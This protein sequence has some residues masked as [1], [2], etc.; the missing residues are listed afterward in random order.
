VFF[1]VL[2]SVYSANIGG[3]IPEAEATP[4]RIVLNFSQTILTEGSSWTVPA[5]WTSGNNTIE[6]IGGGGMGRSDTATSN[7]AGGGGGGA[8]AKSVNVSLTPGST[9]T[10]QIGQGGN[11]SSIDGGDTFFNRTSG[12]AGTC[13]DTTSV[14][15]KGGKGATSATGGTGGDTG[16]SFA[17]GTGNAKFAGGTGGT[18]HTNAD[19]GGG[20]GGAAGPNGAGGAG[21]AGS[22]SATNLSQSGGGGGGNG[23]GGAGLA[24]GASGGN[25]GNGNGGT[26]SGAGADAADGSNGTAGTGAGGGGGGETTSTG[27][28]GGNGATGSEWTTAGTGGGGGG[29]ADFSAASLGGDGGLYG[30]GG[31]G[32]KYGG[33]GAP[34]LI[35]ITYNGNTPTNTT[36]KVPADWNNSNNTIEVIGAGAS[37]YS[38]S[39]S[40]G[41]TGGGGG[42]YSKATNVSLTAGTSV[43]YSIGKG[44]RKTAVGLNSTGMAGGASYFCNSTS[45][46]ST[47]SD[48]AVVAGGA[49]GTAGTNGTTGVGTGGAVTVGTGLSGGNGGRG[50][51]TGDSSGGGGG[52]GQAAKAG[53]TGGNGGTTNTWGGGGGGGGGDDSGTQ[54][55]AGSNATSTTGGAGGNGRAGTGDAAGTG[56]GGDGGGT[57]A[58]GTDGWTGNEWTNA[59]AGGGGGGAGDNTSAFIRGGD[60]GFAGGGGGGGIWGG[61]GGNGIIVITY[62]PIPIY[63]VTVSGTIYNNDRTTPYDCSANNL[64]VR[65]KVNGAGDYTGTCTANTGAYSISNVSTASGDIVTTYLDG[66]TPDAVDVTRADGDNLTM[67]LYQDNVILNSDDGSALTNANIGLWDGDNDADIPFTSNSNTLSFTG[68]GDVYIPTTGNYAPGGSMDIWG[69]Y[70]AG[71]TV[72][73]GS[74]GWS[75]SSLEVAG[76]SF[77]NG[78]GGFANLGSIKQTGGTVNLGSGN[79]SSNTFELT[80]GTFTSTSATL[81]ISG[82]WTHTAGGT[83]NH[84]N[85]TVVVAPGDGGSA[86]WDVA[87]S[88]TLYNL[89]FSPGGNTSSMTISS[90]DTLV[91]T[92]NFTHTTG[93]LN[94]GTVEVQGSMTVGSAG[95]T[96]STVLSFLVSGSQ[97][98][99]TSGGMTGELN[100]AKASGTLSVSGTNLGVAGFT[101]SSGTFTA[102]TGTLTIGS[103]SPGGSGNFTH[104]A[105]GTFSHN[106][107]TVLFAYCDGC[108]PTV[109]VSTSET[110]NNLSFAAGGGTGGLTI[111]SGD[112]LIALGTFTQGASTH[113]GTGT[114][115]ARGNVV[116]NSGASGG[117]AALTL[118]GSN[119]QTVTS[120][121]TL[122]SGGFTINKTNN[123]DTV[124]LASN[125]TFSGDLTITKGVFSQGASYNMTVGAVS[126]GANGTWSNLGTGDVTLGGD[127]SNAGVIILKSNNAGCGG[128]DDIVLTSTNTTKRTWSGGGTFNL[129]N[130]SVSYM[131]G[132]MTTY[133][134]TNGGNNTSWTFA[135]CGINISGLCLLS[136]GATPCTD[137]GTIKVAI[138]GVVQSPTQPTVAGTWTISEVNTPSAGDVVTVWIDGASATHEAVAVTKYDGSGDITT[139]TLIENIVI[140]GSDDTGVTVTNQDLAAY[141]NDDDE[142]L[143]FVADMDDDDTYYFSG[144]D[145]AGDDYSVALMLNP[146]GTAVTYAPGGYVGAYSYWQVA[147]TTNGGSSEW[148]LWGGTE[149]TNGGLNILGGTYNATSD[150][151]EITGYNSQV[152]IS[153]GTFNGGSGLVHLGPGDYTTV[154]IGGSATATFNDV[155][156]DKGGCCGGLEIHGTWVIDGDLAYYNSGYNQF[157]GDGIIELSGNFTSTTVNSSGY[158]TLKFVGDGNQTVTDDRS[159]GEAGLPPVIID[160]PS[161]TLTFVGD[162]KVVGYNQTV[163]EY[164]DGDVDMGNST[165]HFN[166]EAPYIDAAGMNFNNVILETGGCCSQTALFDSLHVLGDLDI[167]SAGASGFVNGDTRPTIYV[168][169]DLY[170]DNAD[171]CD[172]PRGGC[173]DERG[174]NFVLNGT[175]AQTITDENGNMPTGSITIN[176]ASGTVTMDED[177]D[178][179]GDLIVTAGTFDQGAD[180]DLTVNGAVT[181][182]SGG[183]WSNTGTGDVTLGGNVSNAGTVNLDSH[184]F[185][186]GDADD[187]VL[188]STSTTKRTWSGA[189]TFILA[190][191]TVSYMQGTRTTNSS[192]N[193]GNNTNWTFAGCGVTVSGTV[194][195]NEGTTPITSGPTV[196]IKV[197]GAGSYSATANGS[198][199]YSIASVPVGTD[200]IITVYLDGATPDA[201]T[202]MRSGG[203]GADV[204]GVNLYQNYLIV[205][206][207]NANPVTNSD[208]GIYDGDD[209]A[210]L[211]FTANAGA[212]NMNA[213]TTLYINAG[214]TF[215]PDGNVTADGLK[216][217]GAYDNATNNPAL[218]VGGNLTITA[219]G[220]FA[221]GT[222]TLT[223]NEEGTQTITDNSAGQDLGNVQIAGQL[224]TPNESWWN[225]SWTARRKIIFSNAS[226][227]A[228]LTDFPVL[229]TL[230]SSNIDYSK[231]QNTGQDIRFVDADGS[232]ALSYQIEQWNE[233]GDSLVWVKVPSLANTNTDYIW[234][235][236]GN[237]GASDAQASTA[238]WNAGYVG[239]WHL[240]DAMTN[241]SASGTIA[242]STAGNASGTQHGNDDVT[243]AIGLGQEFDGNDYVDFGNTFIADE[244]Q[245]LTLTAWASFGTQTATNNYPG[246]IGISDNALNNK[247]YGIYVSTLDDGGP[248]NQ[249]YGEASDGTNKLQSFGPPY[250]D[251]GLWHQYQMVLDRANDNMLFYTDGLLTGATDISALGSLSNAKSF[252]MGLR[253]PSSFFNGDIDE[254]RAS[255]V[256]RS[257]DWISAEYRTESNQMNTFA[258]EETQSS[259]QAAWWNASWTARRPIYLNNDWSDSSLSNFPVLVTLNSSNID[260]SKTQNT[261]QDIRFVDSDGSTSLSYQIE[262]WNESGDSYVWVKVPSLAANNSDYIWMYYGNNAA[263]DGQDA[264]SVWDSNFK[265]VWHFSSDLNDSTSNG[266]N[267]TNTGTVSSVVGVGGNA[268]SFASG[269]YVNVPSATSLNTTSTLTWS[270]W[271]NNST[272]SFTNPAA[273]MSR[274]DAT[275]S[276]NGL[277]LHLT[278]EFSEVTAYGASCNGDNLGGGGGSE[279]SFADGQ[280]HQ[281]TITL[282][283]TTLSVYIDGVADVFSGADNLSGT[284]SF[285]GQ[286]LRFGRSQDTFWD[287]YTGKLDEARVSNVTRSA[288]WIHA[289]YQTEANQ[290]MG[291][292]A[293]QS[294]NTPTTVVLGSNIKATNFIIGEGQTLSADGAHNLTLTGSD[295]DPWCNISSAACNSSW[296]NRRKITFDNSSLASS[297]TDFPVLVKLDSTNIDYSKTQNAGQDIR[298]VDA[299]GVTVLSYEIEKWDETG[300]SYVWV[301]VPSLANTNSDY[302]WMYYNNAAAT[303]ND[304]TADRIYHV[305]TSAS[306]TSW[307]NA[308]NALTSNDSSATFATTNQNPL[309]VKGFGFNIPSDATITGFELDVEGNGA[310]ATAANRSVQMGLTKNGT[311]LAGSY[312]AAQNLPQTTDD[313]LEFGGN[314]SLFG[315][316]WTPAEVNSANFGIMLRAGNTNN[317]QRAID[318]VDMQIYFTTPTGPDS[319]WN[320]NYKGVWHLNYVNDGQPDFPLTPDSTAYTGWLAGEDFDGCT[321]FAAAS[322]VVGGVAAGALGSTGTECMA[323]DLPLMTSSF[324]VDGWIKTS[325]LG[326]DLQTFFVQT[327]DWPDSGFWLIDNGQYD[328]NIMFGVYPQANSAGCGTGVACMARSAVN[329]GQWHKITGTYDG[330]NLRLY[331]D[332]ALVNTR[333]AGSYTYNPDP[334][335]T[336]GPDNGH[337]VAR[338]EWR[339]SDTARSADWI[340]AEYN[341]EL[342]LMNSYGAEDTYGSIGVFINN[343]TFVAS[344]GTVTLSPTGTSATVAGSGSI[345]FNNFTVNA[346]GKNIQFAAGKTV[347]ITGALTLAGEPGRALNLQSDVAGVQWTVS[348]SGTASLSF[349]SVID[350]ACA[351]GSGNVS[352]GETSIS[353]GNNGACWIF[354]SRGGSTFTGA[355]GGGSGG[356]GASG[357]GGSGGGGSG[358]EG[359][360]GSSGSITLVHHWDLNDSSTSTALDSAGSAN[361]TIVNNASPAT[362]KISG[363]YSFA[364]ASS[365]Y[366]TISDATNPTAYTYSVWI[367]PTTVSAQGIWVRTSSNGPGT[368][369]SHSIR[370]TS[371]GKAQHYTYDGDDDQT[372]TGTTTLQAGNWY[373]ITV[374]AANGGQTKLYV[375]GA[376]EGTP[377]SVGTMWTGGDRYYLGSSTAGT[378]GYFNGVMDD[379][380]YYDGALSATDILN[381]YNTGLAS[382][383]GGGGG[384]S[385]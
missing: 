243:G 2:A 11:I 147:G 195:S 250:M 374:T 260:Y 65:V 300:T 81:T 227:S 64:T 309:I 321:T 20:G 176:K 31:G 5:D 253:D 24:G 69:F 26:G 89:S 328:N 50:N 343:G 215:R 158:S 237:N 289:E 373:M 171:D 80:S 298:F 15:A 30:A 288:D 183:T 78:S 375:N 261:G 178:T 126:V 58:S 274:A 29:A 116:I 164:E 27:N 161:G 115:E 290:M 247:G 301:K 291:F 304:G 334:F 54:S 44:G 313:W 296:L 110:F 129:Y 302:I 366:M 106:N 351:V 34:G 155:E 145:E 242:D 151:L 150:A 218:A 118:T 212:L 16:N 36:W 93:H 319:V 187:I 165:I 265:G 286:P 85:G 263:T 173:G 47:A 226:S 45:N 299:D 75:I 269:A 102:P 239:V 70:Q 130:L 62:E 385:P 217:V 49:G 204:T 231:T 198:G 230:N 153:G 277:N 371:A 79:I 276:C 148:E 245:S 280:W 4:V 91:T 95:A 87:T 303:Y 66:E 190:D 220:T 40:N 157:G 254:A 355:T 205:R 86:I 347:G 201:V 57:G 219:D 193:A 141:T 182:S 213:G 275:S 335:I 37:G 125:V 264:T 283:G 188:T 166:G 7:G 25:G 139:M 362:G 317:S 167:I 278:D 52:G 236:Y 132:S 326:S 156:V 35:V 142:D 272:G 346:A 383:G 72:T 221:K 358:S 206:S 136:D 340:K 149:G 28:D 117:T 369:Y 312:A 134:S 325:E 377:A 364:A 293:E 77:T 308:S 68:G 306:G 131:Q 55:S 323:G 273:F 46:C 282:S 168:G 9:V 256:V 60:G 172:P 1:V 266:N 19:S 135:A 241:E 82:N 271:F 203:D 120:A 90:G 10:Y 61:F 21:G 94:G 53:Q 216:I 84:N 297:L 127:V 23:G 331:L 255:G 73:G 336:F 295:P 170:V 318:Y 354:V 246:I 97:T 310:S 76:G 384:G 262:S 114:I 63:S 88:E 159:D 324:T 128:S 174:A 105:G 59:G 349:V 235:Y 113:I 352:V 232:T 48:T 181:V 180:N 248:I 98:I 196:R 229:V 185:G 191:L 287:P 222:G 337:D 357:G 184:G 104:T 382:S 314:G 368:S 107:G 123:T 305:G 186:C 339:M 43:S 12:T 8:Y 103:T 22:T 344:T 320:S 380:R 140:I 292:G 376:E 121:G 348:F 307:T 51:G 329:D 144:Y 207:E 189:G 356:S 99:T 6:V 179:Y 111:S 238:V 100:V 268:A 361:A 359:G 96:S 122:P 214:D 169:G 244:N 233:S 71:G 177:L 13:A 56:G 365:Q 332:G 101:L 224:G 83:F 259:E 223:L 41:A 199:V 14:C 175:G 225:A 379:F 322:S 281:M 330:A 197:N 112:T 209:D 163:W 353:R 333:S 211:F 363:G 311:A 92:H 3:P 39:N 17:S 327:E 345:S 124:T 192:T 74:A 234:M 279:G 194:Y 249:I 240:N 341:A 133:S 138:N 67:D 146:L 370:I 316:T 160:K 372:V 119:S 360:S 108:G 285:N 162:F 342:G 42:A 257:A 367:K 252:Y 294:S 208:L 38:A 315:T 338:D 228:S 202:V 251:D 143:P 267:G 154:V 137:T 350:A 381:L 152:N 284:F 270:V 258:P 109:N 33:R 378:Y 32:G 18:G 210:D 200:K